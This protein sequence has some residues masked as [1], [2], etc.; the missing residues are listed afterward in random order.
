MMVAFLSK[1]KRKVDAV[2]QGA[3][4]E[5][6][7]YS[8]LSVHNNLDSNFCVNFLTYIYSRKY[9]F[10]GERFIDKGII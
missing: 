7:G 4:E 1:N 5:Q 9:N 6:N 2:L 8:E 10:S 3:K